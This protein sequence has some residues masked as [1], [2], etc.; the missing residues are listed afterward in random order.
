MCRLEIAE[1]SPRAPATIHGQSLPGDV[2]TLG[3][4][5]KE[6]SVGHFFDRTGAAQRYVAEHSLGTV[7]F[8][9]VLT[10]EKILCTFGQGR[11]WS[12]AVHQNSV[13][14]QFDRQRAGQMDYAGLG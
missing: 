8:G 3:R 9:C 6:H 10:I 13:L 12:D 1:E 2:S 14:S 5:K 11:P 4:S 7:L